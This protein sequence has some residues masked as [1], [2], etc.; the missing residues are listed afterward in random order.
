MDYSPPGSSAH[1]IL[2]AR[3]LEWTAIYFS[4]GSSPTSRWNPHLL[5]LL[6]GQADSLP[7]SHQGS[8]GLLL[9]QSLKPPQ[10]HSQYDAI[11][12]NPLA[13]EIHWPQ[14]KELEP[15][16]IGTGHRECTVLCQG[17]RRGPLWGRPGVACPPGAHC[18]LLPSSQQ[19]R[20]GAWVLGEAPF[21]SLPSCCW[22][23][24]SH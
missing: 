8:P 1:V 16:S 6:H 9:V 13:S 14:P 18:K 12:A 5:H 7:L 22:Q 17:G 3:I 24:G 19:I 2:Q 21:H 11:S 4:R 15:V 20:E 23:M 10:Y